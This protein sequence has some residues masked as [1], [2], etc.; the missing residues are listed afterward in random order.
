[1]KRFLSLVIRATKEFKGHVS[2]KKIVGG[3][4]AVFLCVRVFL[5]GIFCRADRKAN[6]F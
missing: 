3:Y 2:V 6:Q 5:F 4:A 1:M